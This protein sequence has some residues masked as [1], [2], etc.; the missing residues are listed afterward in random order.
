MAPKKRKNVADCSSSSRFDAAMFPS[1]AKYEAYAELFANPV[2]G[3]ERHIDE[4]FKSTDEYGSI[5]ARHWNF[6]YTFDIDEINEVDWGQL[7]AVRRI[8]GAINRRSLQQSEA[9]LTEGEDD[10]GDDEAAEGE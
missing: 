5:M 4:S 6:L 7:D 1:L 10:D 2:V 8:R 3:S 9:H